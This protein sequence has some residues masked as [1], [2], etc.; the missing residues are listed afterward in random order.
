MKVVDQQSSEILAAEGLRDAILSGQIAPGTRL[1]EA[2]LSRVLAISRGTLRAALLRLA[3]DGLVVS[4]PNRG[5]S[6]ATLASH[7]VWELYT[8]RNTY[9]SMASRLL[10]SS[11][12]DAKRHLVMTAFEEHQKIVA[13]GDK[14]AIFESDFGLH[15]TIVRLTGH[16]RLR[17]AYQILERQI[18]LFYILCSEFL[19]LDEYVTSHTE[20]VHAI[21]RGDAEAAARAAAVHN[22][23]DGEA[24]LAKLRAQENSKPG[25]ALTVIERS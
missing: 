17:D 16:A 21:C 4:S 15:R 13:A 19:T 8:L 11:I 18:R 6:V 12:D 14:R 7:D 2:D 24:A 1:V 23:A 22:T 3:A 25:P 20:I 10:A 9:E 5:Y